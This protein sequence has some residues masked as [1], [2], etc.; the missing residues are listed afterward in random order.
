MQGSAGLAAFQQQGAPVWV[1]GEQTDRSVAVPVG[2]RISLV[3]ALLVG[4]LELQHHRRAVGQVGRERQG[5]V[6]VP[7]GR[8]ES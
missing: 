4:V 6:G 3:P 2:Q 7:E 5:G 1:V 8:A